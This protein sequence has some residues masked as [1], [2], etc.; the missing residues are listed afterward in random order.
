MKKNKIIKMLIVATIICFGSTTIPIKADVNIDNNVKHQYD[1]VKLDRNNGNASEGNLIIDSGFEDTDSG[2]WKTTGDGTFSNY[3]GAAANGEKFGLLPAN[4][5]NAS[6]Y[7]VVNVKP[8]TDYIAKAKV[9]VAKEG[10]SAFLNVKTPDVSTLIGNAET[11]ITWSADKDWQYQDVELKFNSENNTSIAICVM[12][13]T[14]DQNSATFQG[15]V[16]VDEVYLEESNLDSNSNDDNDDNYE[17]I[18]ADDFNES[19][20]DLSSW[21]YELGSIRGIEQQHYV[22]DPENVFL[23]E[24]DEGGE[25]VLKAT[26]RPEELQYNNPRNESRKVIYNSGSVR[27]HGKEEFLYGRIEMRAKLPEGQ[28]VF[29]AFWT[30][31]S[32]FTIDGDISNS[33]G[34]GWARCGEIDIMELIGSNEGGVGNKTVYQTIHTSDGNDGNDHKLAGVSYTISEDFADDYHIFGINWSKGKMEWYVD[35]QIVKTVDYSNDPIASKCLDRPQY[36]QM[37]LAM[38][39][40][41]PGEI[42]EGLAGTEYAIDYVYYAQNE[43]QK[44]DAEEYYKDSPKILSYDK[45]ITIYEGDTDILSNVAVSDNADIDFSITDAPKFSIKEDTATIE[46]ALTSVDL[47]CTGKK[48]LN[49]LAELPAGEYTVYYTALPE[50][51]KLDTA[52][53]NIPDAYENYKFDRKAANLTIK[54]R[55]L[56]TDLLNN[57]LSLDGYVNDTL[58]T[59]AL[60]DGWSWDVPETVITEDMGDVS[61]TFTKNGF[62][63]TEEVKI[64][65]YASVTLEDLSKIIEEANI[66][67]NKT[68]M[69]TNETLLNLKNVVDNAKA[70]LDI[71]PSATYKDITKAYDDV[72]E[73]IESLVEIDTED[74]NSEGSQEN[75]NPGGSQEDNNPGGSQEDNNSGESQDDQITIQGENDNIINELPK[76]G[77]SNQ[78][79]LVLSAV[80]IL[81]FGTTLVSKRKKSV[82]K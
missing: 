4:S 30:L 34:Y 58:E 28:S 32:D 63:K 40:A 16:Y 13:W 66:Y 14:E 6:V 59:I 60:P 39:G 72:V 5:G 18:W 55:S 61:A 49:S 54:E 65:T 8:N 76:T 12:K 77:G 75:N 38:G 74:N 15:Q 24:N 51:L 10:A 33:Q 21:E 81:G 69:Y 43:Q 82:S 25:L 9:L 47:L 44:L 27:T 67:L 46:T 36:I 70:V 31:G 11:T 50:D 22:N 56:E 42:Q 53:G 57:N 23:R 48:D 35:D 73:A 80:V 26:D 62:E 52:N 45:D 20:L 41:W 3:P 78:I 29:P 2:T 68:D 71:E 7:Q 17:I 37:N 64:N 19:E 1:L 79:Y